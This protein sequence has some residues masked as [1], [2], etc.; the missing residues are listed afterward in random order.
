MMPAK[1]K[2]RRD[3]LLI[4]ILL[5]AAGATLCLT[6][7]FRLPGDWVVVEV[8]GEEWGRY[9]LDKGASIHIETE[10][11]G[12]NVLE[13]ADGCASVIEASCPDKLCVH[14]HR[15]SHSDETI[16]CLPNRVVVSVV[17]GRE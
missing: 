8:D 17:S 12:Y 3:L 6:L 13:I 14:Q 1:C 15:I 16:V 4:F 10:A 11:G 5:L 2:V 9:A 7:L